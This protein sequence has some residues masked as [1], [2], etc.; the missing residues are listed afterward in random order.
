MN[1]PERKKAKIYDFEFETIVRECPKCFEQTIAEEDMDEA[2]MNF[3]K[4]RVEYE[5]KQHKEQ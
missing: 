2:I 4:A 5:K 1:P 3:E